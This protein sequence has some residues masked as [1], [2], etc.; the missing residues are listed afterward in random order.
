MLQRQLNLPYTARHRLLEVA[1]EARVEKGPEREQRVHVEALHEREHVV[2]E[3]VDVQAEDDVA[4]LLVGHRAERGDEPA[5]QQVVHDRLVQR[6]QERLHRVCW[7]HSS[8]VRAR[9]ARK[10]LGL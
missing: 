7:R 9:L 8:G 6:R 4:L 2:A 10:Q 3:A 1:K 5:V